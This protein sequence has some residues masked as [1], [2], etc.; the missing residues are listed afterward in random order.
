MRVLLHALPIY[1][2]TDPEATW[3]SLWTAASSTCHVYDYCSEVRGPAT[4]WETST[5]EFRLKSFVYSHRFSGPVTTNIRNLCF[6]TFEP[7]H[8]TVPDTPP[9]NLSHYTVYYTPVNN[10]SEPTVDSCSSVTWHNCSLCNSSCGCESHA[11]EVGFE[12]KTLSEWCEQWNCNGGNVD[13]NEK[14]RHSWMF[15]ARSW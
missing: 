4:P 2:L 1:F 9:L 6:L 8:L 12:W 15:W 10:N 5:Q 13:S 7:D 3:H 11:W 14:S